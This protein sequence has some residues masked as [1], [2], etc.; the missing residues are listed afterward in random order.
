MHPRALNASSPPRLQRA[1]RAG[2]TPRVPS[3]AHQ[4]PPPPE[5]PPPAAV[6]LDVPPPPRLPAAARQRLGYVGSWLGLATAA[7]P[8]QEDAHAAAGSS[9]AGAPSGAGAERC[10]PGVGRAPPPE[11]P[12]PP[13]PLRLM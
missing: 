8:L 5:P 3:R 13:E 4:P 2:S 7:P 11:P 10:L 12:E 9:G 1:A 6:T